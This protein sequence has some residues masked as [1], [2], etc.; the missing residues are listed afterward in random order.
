MSGAVS[1]AFPAGVIGC[2][3]DL[4]LSFRVHGY[5]DMAKQTNVHAFCGQNFGKDACRAFWAFII[6]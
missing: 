1:H 2:N 3:E 4:T 5:L 6:R